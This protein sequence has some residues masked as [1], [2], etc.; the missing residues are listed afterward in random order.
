MQISKYKK[1]I[2]III[3]VI[4]C[5]GITTFAY[6]Q[7]A[8]EKAEKTNLPYIGTEI[9]GEISGGKI[10]LNW[11][12]IEH[13]K[14][15]GYK[16]VISKN[17]SAPAYPA[18]GYLYFITDNNITSATIDNSESYKDGDFGQNLILGEKYY[19]SITVM[20]TDK[21]IPGDSIQLIYPE[22]AI[23]E[24]NKDAVE[25]KVSTSENLNPA[26]TAANSTNTNYSNSA[27]STMPT[28][29]AYQ[30][31]SRVVVKWKRIDSENL[32]GYKVVISKKDNTPAYP[33]NGYLAWITN[34]NTTQ[35]VV[36]NS[37]KY[38]GGDFGGYLTPGEAYYFSVTAVYN[39]SKIPG[40]AV[41]LTYPSSGQKADNTESL[42][43]IVISAKPSGSNL[44]LSWPSSQASNFVGYKVVISKNNPNLKY[45]DDGY[46][47]W[48]TDR[49]TTSATVNANTYYGGD[50]N[51]KLIPGET[52]YFSISIIY[53]GWKIVPGPSIKA[54]IPS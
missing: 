9:T 26:E 48:I 20:Y 46:L 4:L 49:N 34:K 43:P 47:K 35:W 3:A 12:K 37:S 7:Y 31:G 40:N 36:D 14:F 13:P 41:H 29:T 5:L 21:T 24:K 23:G 50:I 8:K 44:I 38:N 19:F 15:A 17:N 39:D 33:E 27:N 53:D 32:Q 2:I 28:V 22:N 42:A 18:E 6:A 54:K 25:Q 30:D 45:P 10:I 11:Q 1:S 16:V 52:Y 51:G